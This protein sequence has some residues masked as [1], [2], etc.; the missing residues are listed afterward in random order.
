MSM[1]TPTTVLSHGLR[2]SASAR[3]VLS[4]GLLTAT[5]SAVGHRIIVIGRLTYCQ[6]VTGRLNYRQS[7][8]GRGSR[9]V[10]VI[11]KGQP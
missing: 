8:T 1:G 7:V 11:G 5:S 3:A 10:E 2:P 6:N 9:R 4:H